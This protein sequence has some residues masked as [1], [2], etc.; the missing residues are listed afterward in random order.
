LG[1]E[2]GSGSGPSGYLARSGRI[3]QSIGWFG[4]DK[5][6]SCS[7]DTRAATRSTGLT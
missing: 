1:K 4:A 7:V 2:M 6:Y 5:F 3:G